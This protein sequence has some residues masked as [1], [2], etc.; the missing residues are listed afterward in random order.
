MDIEFSIIFFTLR[1][2]STITATFNGHTHNDEMIV[3]FDESDKE[4]IGVAYN[5]GSLTTYSDLNPNYRIYDIDS[6]NFVSFSF[7]T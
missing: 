3:Y 2:S 6:S 4:S 7:L 1:F 5:G